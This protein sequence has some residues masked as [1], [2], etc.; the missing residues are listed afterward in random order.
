[1]CAHIDRT[2]WRDGPQTETLR[3]KLRELYPVESPR[4][5]S[6]MDCERFFHDYI[7]SERTGLL[8][9][10]IEDYVKSHVGW[11]DR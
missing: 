3:L 2:R 4:A 5:R 7:M 9:A 1:M 8:L 11:K 10:L 6:F